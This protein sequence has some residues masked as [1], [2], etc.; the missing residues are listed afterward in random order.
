MANA[1]GLHKDLMTKA[2][3]LA[4]LKRSGSGA[5][6]PDAISNFPFVAHSRKASIIWLPNMM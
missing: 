4:E 5:E 3:F 6:S 2:G 1:A